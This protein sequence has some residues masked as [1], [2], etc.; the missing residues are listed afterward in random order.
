M[1]RLRHE[2]VSIFPGRDESPLEVEIVNELKRGAKGYR[3]CASMGEWVAN[4]FFEY[5][6]NLYKSRPIFWHVASSQG[7]APFAFGAIV[8]YHRFD[9]N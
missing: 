5:H 3:K 1:E 6:K 7:I 4:V 8:H 9:K 2:L